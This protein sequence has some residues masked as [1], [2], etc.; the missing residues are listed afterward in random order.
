MCIIE[1]EAR[2]TQYRHIVKSNR[3]HSQFRY[4]REIKRR[5]TCLVTAENCHM[6]SLPMP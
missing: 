1:K 4:T 6:C 5:E 2:T 3:S